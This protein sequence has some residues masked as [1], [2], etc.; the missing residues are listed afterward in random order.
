VAFKY[1]FVLAASGG[2]LGFFTTTSKALLS[3]F[4]RFKVVG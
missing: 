4:S 3:F 2:I 1:R